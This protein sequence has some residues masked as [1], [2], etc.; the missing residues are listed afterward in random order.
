M[1][2]YYPHAV[3][4]NSDKILTKGKMLKNNYPYFLVKKQDVFIICII[5]I[6]EKADSYELNVQ[7]MET[8][9]IMLLNENIGLLDVFFAEW[10][11]LDYQNVEEYIENQIMYREILGNTV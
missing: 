5:S 10:V 3:K 11:I 6:C 4:I 7:N 2:K 8:G 9:E 1:I